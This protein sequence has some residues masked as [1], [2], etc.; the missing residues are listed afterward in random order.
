MSQSQQ[1]QNRNVELSKL[2]SWILRHGANE[3]KL[4]IDGNGYVDID[5]ILKHQRFVS[6]KFS[7]MEIKNVVSNDQK[8]RFTLNSLPN[9][10]ML[11]RANQGHSLT[12]VQ[13]TM[14]IVDDAS[15]LPVA[16]HG[17]YYRFWEKIKSEGLKR[18]TRNHIHLTE[19]EHFNVE[20]S[21]FR[22]SSEILIYINV[23]KAMADGIVFYRSANNVILT[24]G[25]D[26]VLSNEYFAKVIDRT[27]KKPLL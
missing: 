22:S 25:I 23:R 1:N 15:K 3:E 24:E 21:G 13:M 14:S 20:I 10:K 11:I 4:P 18:M 27:T 9:G 5:I 6:K 12:N 16:V 19:S 7:L 8:Q 2:L 26:G 17:T